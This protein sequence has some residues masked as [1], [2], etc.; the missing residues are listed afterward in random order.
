[1]GPEQARSAGPVRPPILRNLLHCLGIWPG[2]EI[3]QVLGSDLQ[4]EISGRPGISM[5][6]GRKQKNICS[7]LMNLMNWNRTA[8]K[9]N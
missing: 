2:V 5:T 6:H 8:V 4:G 3:K 1:M 7:S 9:M